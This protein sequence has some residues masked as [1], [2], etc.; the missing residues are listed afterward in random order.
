MRIGLLGGSFDPIHNAHL[1]L[2]KAALAG[3]SLDEVWF[4][5]TAHSYHKGRALI[6]AEDRV[7]MIEAA[8]A[9]EPCFKMCDID[10]QR[11][12][13]TY[14]ADTLR[15]LHSQYPEDTFVF[16][17]GTDSFVT[18]EY[19][20]EPEVIF[21]LAEIG[22]ALRPGSEEGLEDVIGR[23]K[24]KYDARILLL[25]ME[26]EDI[27]SSDVRKKVLDGEPISDYVPAGVERYIREHEI[28]LRREL[29]PLMLNLYRRYFG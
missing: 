14:T 15:D 20:K 10:L 19:W 27:S 2:G 11:G 9:C 17:Q 7:A 21:A 3:L 29:D 16:L 28:D 18:M 24:E 12:G 13:N 25:P 1:K 22:V 5:P 23:L 8:I 6:P 4:I 26:E